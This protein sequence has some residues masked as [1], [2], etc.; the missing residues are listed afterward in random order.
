MRLLLPMAIEFI[1]EKKN[2]FTATTALNLRMERAAW[3]Q[4]LFP[5]LEG[6]TVWI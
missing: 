4:S 6:E 3:W 5:L 2:V 1:L